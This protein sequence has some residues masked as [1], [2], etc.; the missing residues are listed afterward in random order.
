MLDMK[1]ILPYSSFYQ[2]S[3]FYNSEANE[4]FSVWECAMKL[5]Y[6]VNMNFQE[7]VNKLHSGVKAYR[8]TWGEGEFL[9]KKDEVL[10]H[11]TPYW[12]GELINQYLNGYPYVCEKRDV[13][14]T[15]WILMRE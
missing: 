10:V 13:D 9:W 1:T 11:N 6:E 5:I 4:F 2:M 8:P 3:K 12:G 15:D 7:M 14:A